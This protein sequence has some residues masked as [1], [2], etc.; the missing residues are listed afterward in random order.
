ME[1]SKRSKLITTSGSNGS[2]QGFI[3]AH[4]AANIV[5]ISG[6]FTFTSAGVPGAIT[7]SVAS[8]Q[9]IPIQCTTIVPQTGNVIGLLP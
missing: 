2:F 1:A 6:P 4:S 3:N 9:Y 7:M 5:G 8:G